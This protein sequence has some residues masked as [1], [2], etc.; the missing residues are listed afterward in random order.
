MAIDEKDKELENLIE[1]VL[2]HYQ[3][4]AREQQLAVETLERAVAILEED[5]L[6]PGDIKVPTFPFI[7]SK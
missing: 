1:R 2:N 7:P 3:T 5:L 4:I 6:E